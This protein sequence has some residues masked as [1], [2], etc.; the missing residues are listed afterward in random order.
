MRCLSVGILALAVSFLGLF[1]DSDITE[2]ACQAPHGACLDEDST[3]A[4]VIV[5]HCAAK[6]VNLV[7][8]EPDD[9]DTWFIV[10]TH[11]TD[12]GTG[13]PPCD[14]N[15]YTSSVTAEVSWTGSDWSVSCTGCNY[16]N[17]PIMA[18]GVC[19]VEG[20]IGVSG[21]HSWK[22][23]LTARV[24]QARVNICSLGTTPPSWTDANLHSVKFTTTAVDDGDKIDTSDCS[25]NGAVSPTSQT[26]TATDFAFSCNLNCGSVSG[27]LFTIAYE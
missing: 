18:L 12:T 11:S 14:C 25:E 17:G 4:G 24:K 21:T 8:V 15:D 26:W 3:M 1:G 23:R 10:A 22:Y 2:A 20:C 9:T 27:P 13:N 16:P 7:H 5:D 19:A 6:G